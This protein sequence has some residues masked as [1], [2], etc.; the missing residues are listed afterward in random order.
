M[1][2]CCYGLT[3]GREKSIFCCF[4]ISHILLLQLVVHTYIYQ[5][6]EVYGTNIYLDIQLGVRYLSLFMYAVI[7]WINVSISNLFVLFWFIKV[8]RKTTS[9]NEAPVG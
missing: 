8:C 4:T 2:T 5:L 9:T 6:L 7:C 1:P 3:G